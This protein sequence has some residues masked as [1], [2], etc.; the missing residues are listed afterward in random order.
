MPQANRIC[1]LVE[2]FPCD[3]WRRHEHRF[4]DDLRDYILESGY[5]AKTEQGGE[6]PA[7]DGPVDIEVI[8]DPNNVVAIEVKKDFPKSQ[9]SIDRLRRQIE[10]F[11]Q[12]WPYLIVCSFGIS[13]P[14]AWNDMK[15]LY[16]GGYGRSKVAFIPKT[17]G[18]RNQ[19]T[20]ESQRQ[21]NSYNPG[22]PFNDFGNPFEDMDR[23][24]PF[25]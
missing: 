10:Q 5:G 20:R 18:S 13:D 1:E 19:S 15:N 9:Q 14:Q 7:L 21:N 17:K 6:E 24:N 8:L 2:Q 11:T 25:F 16:S 23:D 12:V 4:R 3:T 22:N